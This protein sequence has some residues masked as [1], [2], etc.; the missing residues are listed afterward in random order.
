MD[1]TLPVVVVVLSPSNNTWEIFNG[2][3]IRTR[4]SMRGENISTF[5]LWL[6]IDDGRW[7]TWEYGARH[8]ISIVC[9]VRSL[10]SWKFG[11]NNFLC[12][13]A[14][15]I[16]IFHE[17]FFVFFGQLFPTE[18]RRSFD[19]DF[20]FFS[21]AAPIRRR[22]KSSWESL[23]FAFVLTHERVHATQ[24]INQSK[25]FPLLTNAAFYFDSQPPSQGNTDRT[26]LM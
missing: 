14:P 21:S 6:F 12:R 9:F 1:S 20:F 23:P 22:L 8:L 17:F 15:I 7:H 19:F 3:A 26:M 25:S 4:T 16:Y 24:T 5:P 18:S 10:V 2:L 13:Q 11:R